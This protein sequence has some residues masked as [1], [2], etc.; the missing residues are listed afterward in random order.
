MRGVVHLRRDSSETKQKILTVCVR[1]FLEQGYKSTSV[2]QIVEEAGVARGSYLNLF[3]T[4]DKILLELFPHVCSRTRFSV[5]SRCLFSTSCI[6][7]FSDISV[8]I[9]CDI[10]NSIS[11]VINFSRPYGSDLLL[12]FV[13]FALPAFIIAKGG[14][15]FTFSTLV[16]YSSTS[17]ACGFIIEEKTQISLH[18]NVQ[19]DFVLCVIP[20]R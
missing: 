17:L 2:S 10:C 4:K 8:P 1:L 19:G 3:P 16:L 7:L 13:R 15:F 18:D 14:P 20:R 11:Y 12:L 5:F 6:L 9:L